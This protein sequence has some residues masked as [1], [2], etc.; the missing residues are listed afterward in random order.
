MTPER[1]VNRVGMIV[2]I[3]A[4]I[5]TIGAGEKI[6][7]Q[8]EALKVWREAR[9]G[10]IYQAGKETEQAIIILNTDSVPEMQQAIE[11]VDSEGG[12]VTHVFPPQVL[13]G[14]LPESSEETLLQDTDI[15]LIDRETLD[16][17]TVAD[18][19][20]E[21]EQAVE[22]W[23]A[24]F[25]NP[26]PESPHL[27]SEEI[28]K[29]PLEDAFLP[30]NLSLSTQD[31]T[32][33]DNK[34]SEY[35]IGKVAVGIVF[36]ESDGSLDPSTEDWTSEEQTQVFNKIVAATDWWAKLEPGADL[37]FY[38]DV[39][40]LP[41]GYEPI[42]HPHTD[43]NLWI[44]QIMAES[45]ND[46]SSCFLNTRNYDNALRQ[47]LGTDWA[48]TIFVV[49][50]SNDQD[51]VFTDG[52]FAYA[53]FGG[54]FLVMTYNNDG[55]GPDNLDAVAAHEIGHIFYAADQ[56]TDKPCTQTSGYLQVENQNSEYGNCSSNAPSLM[57][58][59]ISPF[60]NHDLD[61]YA[62]GQIGWWD[63]DH[64]GILDAIDQDVRGTYLYPHGEALTGKVP[65][66]VEG[67]A[68]DSNKVASVEYRLDDNGV[69]QLAVPLDG[70]FN[71]VSEP[72]RIPSL[73]IPS[74]FQ[75]R[76]TDSKGVSRVE[77]HN[78]NELGNLPLFIW[79]PRISA[80]QH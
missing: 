26:Q 47:S 10:V 67:L 40:T 6:N 29:E 71:G 2:T 3:P 36:P 52:Y 70:K 12:H 59:Y 54:P 62:R 58:G 33:I 4:L 32:E 48:F 72:F 64:D 35:M 38:Y 77:F 45:G 34:T 76:I 65:I 25:A 5:A 37:T 73:P 18:L 56:Y 31:A 53:F 57:R 1:L 41:T 14:S 68:V 49:D 39:K 55:Y 30:R 17:S 15:K 69:W 11:A 61:L 22:I 7:V 66:S 8:Q 51:G 50:S 79:L 42:N 23:N 28:D 74:L 43:E 75:I 60:I 44:N 78:S 63:L 27:P 24:D 20:K 21:G 80:G 9:S 16:P 13:I 19:G 46:T